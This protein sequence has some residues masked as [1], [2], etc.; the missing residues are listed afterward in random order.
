MIPPAS[1]IP[2]T[3]S[4]RLMPADLAIV[5]LLADSPGMITSTPKITNS[6]PMNDRRSNSFASRQLC[7]SSG[8]RSGFVAIA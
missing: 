2:P 7:A 5:A 6:A 8:V 1:M 4:C 3:H